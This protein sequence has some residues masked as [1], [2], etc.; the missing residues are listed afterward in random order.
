MALHS[1]CAMTAVWSARDPDVHVS[2]AFGFPRDRAF[3]AGGVGTCRTGSGGG[4]PRPFIAGTSEECDV[5]LLLP[6]RFEA[7]P[8]LICT[9]S[10]GGELSPGC[11]SVEH[12]RTLSTDQRRPSSHE[13]RRQRPSLS[14][15][16]SCLHGP[17]FHATLHGQVK[18][19]HIGYSG[20][21]GGIVSEKTHGWRE[22]GNA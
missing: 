15:G 22:C 10:S 8:R 14:S 12:S 20:A 2:G 3:W 9:T 16:L 21:M 13:P 7:R 1:E 4:W 11:A 18:P 17:R 19:P 5:Q 6:R